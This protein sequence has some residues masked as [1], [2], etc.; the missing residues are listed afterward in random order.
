M[1]ILFTDKFAELIKDIKYK[2]H[3]PYIE[4]K[5]KLLTR[6]SINDI[7]ATEKLRGNLKGFRSIPIRKHYILIF[8]YCGDCINSLKLSACINV[9]GNITDFKNSIIIHLF[10]QHDLAYKIAKKLS[11]S[12]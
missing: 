5:L 12:F 9:C 10:E 4:N 3:L 6:Y 8:S 2:Q 7:L 11:N 1:R